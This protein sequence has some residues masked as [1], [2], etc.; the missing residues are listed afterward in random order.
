M[1][2]LLLPIVVGIILFKQKVSFSTKLAF[3]I[4]MSGLIIGFV[5]LFLGV[6]G[7]FIFAPGNNLAPIIGFLYTGPIGFMLGLIA[8]GIYWKVKVGNKARKNTEQHDDQKE[9]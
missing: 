1:I 3:Y 9:Q 2:I 7:A 8:G 5:G 4:I 6:I